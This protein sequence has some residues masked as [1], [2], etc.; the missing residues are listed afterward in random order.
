MKSCRAQIQA[1][2]LDHPS[3][4]GEVG[5]RITAPTGGGIT[6]HRIIETRNSTASGQ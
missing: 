3:V 6:L 1:T 5:L 4:H 2:V